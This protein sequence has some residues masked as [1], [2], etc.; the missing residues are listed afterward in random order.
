MALYFGDDEVIPFPPRP[1]K[2]SNNP[3][4]QF[5]YNSQIV[6]DDVNFDDCKKLYNNDIKIPYSL[7]Y[8]HVNKEDPF[9]AYNVSIKINKKNTMGH[10]TGFV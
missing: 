1:T 2:I 3:G 10:L 6:Y 9:N 5:T 8:F 4:S 7:N